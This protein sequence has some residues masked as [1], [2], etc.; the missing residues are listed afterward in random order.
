[1][2]LI[3]GDE[4]NFK[5]GAKNRF[6]EGLKDDLA[7]IQ[8]LAKPKWKMICILPLV[9]GRIGHGLY[10]CIVGDSDNPSVTCSLFIGLSRLIASDPLSRSP[11]TL[12][13]SMGP[14]GSVSLHFGCPASCVGV[15]RRRCS[16]GRS[17]VEAALCGWD[18]RQLFSEGV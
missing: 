1:M 10:Q 7:A 17:V 16:P 5:D 12:K 8:T 15:I 14:P 2:E 4:H 6:S 13:N 9:K 3:R 18:L 11:L